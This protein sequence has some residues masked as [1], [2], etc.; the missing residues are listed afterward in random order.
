V[1]FNF[2]NGP[3]EEEVTSDVAVAR[4]PGDAKSVYKRTVAAGIGLK[5]ITVLRLPAYG[6][7]QHADFFSGPNAGG[8]ARARGELIIRK[9]DVV[10]TLT[11]EN[12]GPYA[13]A[14]CLDSATPPKMT[15]AQA[16]A[17]LKKYAL[18]QRARIGNG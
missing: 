15:K 5:G 10:W 13:P 18:K 14:G 9:H 8:A 7:Q 12:C 2:H 16:M 3:Q 17:E 6:D 11:V 1:T 4:N